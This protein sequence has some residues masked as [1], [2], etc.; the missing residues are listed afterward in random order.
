MSPVSDDSRRARGLV[1]GVGEVWWMGAAVADLG[2]SSRC[3]DAG[4]ARAGMSSESLFS[5]MVS[6][7]NSAS[8]KRLVV[9]VSSP[10]HTAAYG[11]Q[12]LLT[13]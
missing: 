12:D 2:C 5:L 3:S 9:P 6:L 7:T 1:D 11:R 8:F 4:S 13:M 10:V